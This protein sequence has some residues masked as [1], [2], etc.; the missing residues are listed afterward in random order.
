MPEAPKGLVTVAFLKTRLDQGCDHLG[1]FEPLILDAL[2]H[3]SMPDFLAEDIKALVHDRT[4]LL[5]PV[6]AVQTLLGRCTKR[7]LLRREG[8]RF[9]R[10]SRPIPDSQLESARA[11]VQD[12]LGLL[13]HA[14]VRF[15]AD[16]DVPVESCTQALEALS[17]FISDNKVRV[18]L[19]EP[20]P[21]SPLARSTLDRKLTRCIAR[22]VTDCCLASPEL[23]PALAALTDGILLLDALLMRDFPEASQRFRDLSVVLDTPVLFA[24]IDLMGVANA[25][26]AKEGLALLR[27]AGARTIAFTQT[28]EE[29]RRIL[30]FYAERIGTTNGRLSLR[31]TGIT[32]HV[33]TERLSPTDLRFI[34]IT[35]EKRLAN[36]GV[37]VREVPAHLA[38]Y[39]RDEEALAKALVDHD[40]PDLDT[41]RIRHDVDCVAGVLTLRA[42]KVSTSI[43]R[44][45]AI[46]CTTSGRVIQNVQQ[47]FFSQDKQDIPPVVHLAALTSIAWL[48]K[49]AAAPDLKIH[50]LAALCVA[51]MRPT[52]ATMTKFV[53]TLR[54]LRADGSVTDDETAAI[55]AS[56]LM[57]PLLARLD[58]EFEPD[59]DSIQE[60]IER[61]RETYR[62][63]AAADAERAVNKAHADAAAAQLAAEEAVRTARAEAGEAQRSAAEAITSRS[64]VI[65]GVEQRVAA[66]SKRMSDVVYWA[67]VTVVVAA[68]ILS[69][70]G[71]LETVDEAAK[72]IARAVL[73]FALGLGTYSVVQGAS[74]NTI[75]SA[76]QDRIARWI[77]SWWLP[78]EVLGGAATEGV[79]QVRAPEPS[80]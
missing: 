6:N 10:T 36:I 79:E 59:S 4:G 64:Q 45:V 68:T 21:D 15:A 53:E 27:E 26:A 49:P 66:V 30:A 65:A 5:L 14:F 23:R 29:M 18:V 80:E 34:S 51:A 74:L 55:V 70:P 25:V 22:F 58:D 28:I 75:R 78:P 19:N 48:K 54:Q 40:R 44:S 60:A 38:R 73:I 12:Q 8:G 50:E 13:G 72:W 24:A 17:T 20:L 52:P 71:V 32:Q 69:L 46:F 76:V 16:H 61:V 47:W 7:G 41:P 1:L 42:D 35:L 67:C 56:Q 2:A 11:V 39:T 9:F 37:D 57:E 43:E 31:Q 3:I 63:E 33:L 77:R 62:C